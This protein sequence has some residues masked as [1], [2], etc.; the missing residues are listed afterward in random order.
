[1]EK[2]TE[3]MDNSM[4]CISI[5]S[6][7]LPLVSDCNI[8]TASEGFFHM[9]RTAGFNVLIY[10][11]DRVMY[12]TE[13]ERDHEIAA[14]EL[15]ILKSGVRHYGKRE[16]PRGTR[17]IYAHFTL[18]ENET[19]DVNHITLPKKASFLTASGIEQKLFRLCE[20]FHISDPL[21]NMRTNAMLYDILLDIGSEKPETE[22]LSEKICRFLD[23]HT[24]SDFSKE[25]L[26]GRFF[27][28]YSHMAAEFKRQSGMSMGQY[29]NS[30]RMKKACRL[31]RSTLLS[32][33]EIADRLGF[34]DTMYFSRKFRAYAGVSPTE[35]RKQAQ[36]KY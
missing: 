28:S 2:C 27:L 33:G 6:H 35:Y 15:L 31:L 12:V 16:T 21:S 29:H 22:S 36:K 26:G 34:S 23:A 18:P 30:A 5:G 3:Y 9:D 10:V 14:G 20:G 25:L 24:D 19:T 8:L 17:W 7:A 4:N 1:M 11:T 13:D 32:V